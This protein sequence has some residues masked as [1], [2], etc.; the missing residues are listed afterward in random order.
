MATYRRTHCLA[1][2]VRQLLDA[3]TRPP[4]EIIVVNNDGAAGA[5]SAVRAV[6]PVDPRI[7][8]TSCLTGRQ[9]ACRNLGLTL[10]TGDYVAFVDDDDDYAPTYVDALAGALDLGIRSVRAQI[11]TCGMAGPDCTGKPTIAH[12]PLTPNTMAR[13]DTLTPTW[14]EPPSEDR[15]YWERHP[16]EGAIDDCVVFTCRGQG[17]HSPRNNTQGGSWRVRFVISALVTRDDGKALPAFIAALREQTY[18]H[19]RVVLVDGT[20]EDKL[21]RTFD[22]LVA[23]DPRFAVVRSD[24]ADE[25]AFARVMRAATLEPFRDDDVIVTLRANERLAHAGVLNRLAHVYGEHDEVWAT[26]GTCVTE[27]FVPTWPQASFPPATAQ[28]RRFRALPGVIGEY[29]PLTMRAALANTLARRTTPADL[30]AA[31]NATRLDD[32]ADLPLFLAALE[33]AGVAHVYPMAD[34]QV[35]KSLEKAVYKSA[36]ARQAAF[37]RQLAVRSRP[38]LP[39][40]VSLDPAD[41]SNS[42]AAD[43]APMIAAT[44]VVAPPSPP[45]APAPDEN[46]TGTPPAGTTTARVPARMSAD[47]LTWIGAAYD[48]SGYGNELRQFVLAL[49]DLG[50]RPALLAVGNRSARFKATASA[51]LRDRLDL[52]CAE[53]PGKDFTAVIHL[54]PS[55]LQPVPGAEYNIARTMFE[56][57]GLN[58][59]FVKRCNDMHEIWV[60]SAFN[61]RTFRKAGVRAH[62]ERMPGAIDSVRFRPGHDPLRIAEAHGTVFL[63]TVEWKP[64]KG[65]NTLLD[66]WAEAFSPNDDVTLVFRSSVPG[67]SERDSGPEIWRQIDEHLASRG[68]TRRDVANIVVLGRSIP[69]GDIPRLYAAANCYVA[70]TSGEGW[71]YPYMEAMASGL[72]TIATRWSGH[73]DFMHDDNSLLCEVE[74]FIPAFDPYVGEMPNQRWAQPSGRHLAQLLRAV[75]D[76]PTRMQTLSTH[77]RLDMET[78]WTW[79]RAASRVQRRLEELTRKRHP[80]RRLSVVIPPAPQVN[81]SDVPVRWAGPQ[82][83][84]S[85]LGL[86]NRDICAELLDGHGI[87]L[88]V[89]P[90]H[91]HDFRP[92][93]HSGWGRVAERMHMASSHYPA[94][95][96]AVH[97]AHQWPPEFAAPAEGAWVLMQPWEYGGLPGEWIP[98]I[99]DQVDEYWVYCSWQRECAI[100]S[101]IPADKVMIIPLGVDPGRYR[102]DG[103]KYPLVTKKKT[104]LLA[105]GG[106]IP[107]KGMD[108]LVETYLRTFTANDDVCLVIKGLSAR[109]AYNGNS[110]QEDFAALPALAAAEGAAEI[111]FIGDTLDDDAVAS[112]Y[113]ACDALVAPF[114]GEGFGLPIV[115]AMA[116]EL[117]V[118]VTHAGPVFDLC[119]EDSAYLISAGQSAVSTAVAGAEPGRLGFWWADP[120]PA[121]LARH[122]RHVVENPEAARAMGR[123]ARARVLERFTHTRTAMRVAERVHDLAHRVPGRTLP[124]AAFHA[125]VEPAVLDQPRGVVF[126]HHPWWHQEA[127]RSVVS[128]FMRTFS[129]DDDVSLVLL[130]DPAQGM[131]ESHIAEVI[132][133]IREAAERTETDAPDILLVP[134]EVDAAFIA[135]LY[136]AADCVIAG[137]HEHTATCRA[138]AMDVPVCSTL[139]ELRVVY[140]D[141]H[142]ALVTDAHVKS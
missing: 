78:R 109:W 129:Q 30:A 33:V 100:E 17:Q 40:C 4:H 132:A 46:K 108:L 136:A 45:A 35:I 77:A 104:K 92:E 2:T 3:Q 65:W 42:P 61:E 13:R 44:A 91:V 106:I 99:R 115:E 41:V 54:P 31:D 20:G 101:G 141:A 107:R 23:E 103:P 75:V 64:R 131:D 57:D 19:F 82:F 67:T 62:I 60:P 7:R 79:T 130:H 53:P 68:R 117:P 94:R 139:D 123:R 37:D 28:A 126:F 97:V 113:R 84:H 36:A 83:T 52:L 124:S 59:E 128:N 111:E 9:G 48:P 80:G 6:L 72:P 18:R 29:A 133:A 26:Y 21:R 55:F 32:D 86:V 87:E 137:P 93:R 134:G 22:K 90:A 95:P 110:G 71:G 112:L 120:D 96:A 39:L 24:D 74:T 76:E 105:V 70:A 47:R 49:D 122:M 12:H 1:E 119:D 85:S 38:A 73:L 69:D 125:Q 11:Q 14:G 8:V 50:T 88:Y 140:E 58:R 98:L 89:R 56:T 25:F 135:S 102:P 114:R 34:V 51:Q 10:A 121:E 66:A 63:S 116:S 5:E 15:D 16:V 142:R 27:P 118:I 81:T 43:E 127:W 138:T